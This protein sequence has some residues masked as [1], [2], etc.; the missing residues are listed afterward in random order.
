MSGLVIQQRLS[1]QKTSTL[2]RPYSYGPYNVIRGQKQA[3]RL[4][5]GCVWNCPNYHEPTTIKIFD[6]PKIECNEV[7]IFDMNLLCKPQA[8]DLIMQLGKITVKDEPVVYELVCGIDYRFLTLD[9]AYALFKSRFGYVGFDNKQH[10]GNRTIRLAWDGKF[11][12]QRR[13]KKTIGMLNAAGY[14]PKDIMMFIQCNYSICSYEE[15]LKKLDLL[16]VWGC[17]VCDCYYDGQIGSNIKPI[18]WSKEQ[19]TS[20]RAKCR[21]HNQ[22]VN[23]GIDPEVKEAFV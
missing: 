14:K 4:T 21:K 1:D 7:L 5:E 2:K 3:I 8:F 17:R 16:K 22:L 6:I 11:G 13:I 20:F 9:L 10:I 19:I 12:E 23:F 15:C 18:F